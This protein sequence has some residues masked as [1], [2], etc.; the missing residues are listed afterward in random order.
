MKLDTDLSALIDAEVNT[1]WG[2]THGWVKLAE[3]TEFETQ[4][5]LTVRPRRRTYL[6]QSEAGYDW[7][8]G[9]EFVI[10]SNCPHR[11][12]VVASDEVRNLRQ[13][14]YTHVHIHYNRNSAPLEIDL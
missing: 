3:L 13:M 4:R 14:G 1:L 8:V 2:D 6:K 12:N 11:G 7:A 5:I 10:V 9:R